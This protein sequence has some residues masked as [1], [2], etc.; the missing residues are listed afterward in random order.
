M[1]SDVWI[2][3]SLT[4]GLAAYDPLTKDMYFRSN[5]YIS[6]LFP[7]EFIH[8]FQDNYYPGGIDQ[9]RK[10]TMVGFANI[11]FEAKLIQDLLCVRRDGVCPALAAG[12]NK[13]SEYS[14]WIE[15]IGRENDH[16]PNYTELLQ[17]SPNWGNY[18]YWDFL[19]DFKLKYPE[20]NKPTE[21]NLTPKVVNF[22][23]SG[24]C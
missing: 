3:P 8:F 17:R 13:S 24:G 19:E 12:L 9:Y 4:D 23:N 6:T 2:N 16:F 11:E 10:N 14:E 20:Y 7:E 1:L 21:P 15:E 5:D 22:L 18:N